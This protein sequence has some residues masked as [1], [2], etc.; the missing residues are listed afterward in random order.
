LHLVSPHPFFHN[1][2]TNQLI[3]LTLPHLPDQINQQSISTTKNIQT[4]KPISQYL[5]ITT[6]IS[7]ILQHQTTKIHEDLSFNL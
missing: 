4:T 1:L 5:N 6:I 7:P 3:Q 2:H